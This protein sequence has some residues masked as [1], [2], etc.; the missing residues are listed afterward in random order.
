MKLNCGAERHHYSMLTV[1][2]WRIQRW[3]FDAYSPPLED[4]MFSLFDI[5]YSS[6]KPTPYGVNATCEFLQNN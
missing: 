6:I 1:R 3:T 2:L 5:G 4:A